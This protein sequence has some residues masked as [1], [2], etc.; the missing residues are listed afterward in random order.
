MIDPEIGD[1]HLEIKEKVDFWHTRM[2]SKLLRFNTMADFWR[3][4]KPTRPA[5]LSGFA[6]PQST[7]TTR[8]TE[9]I[10][11]FLYRALTA[12]QP[13]F[14][15]L[16]YNPMV[17]QEDL[18]TA[19]SVVGWQM[20]A[21]RYNRKL[22]KACR[23]AALFGT[24]MVEEPWV[25]NTPYF[26]AT[27]FVP[28]S[29][30]QTGFDPLCFDIGSSPWKFVLDFVTEDQLR[31]MSHKMPDVWDP[32]VMEDALTLS[33]QTKNIPPEVNARLANAG[34][35]SYLGSSSQTSKMYQLVIY[36]GPLKSSPTGEFC[37]A[38]L[39]DNATLKAHKSVYKRQPFTVA[40]L[41]EF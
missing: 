40:H 38:T 16:S 24:V 4:L 2:Q 36:Y 25:V 31:A 14:Q 37:A 5:D 35:Q 10:A 23:S 9:A 41:N 6:N 22:L 33:S 39:N 19:E 26:E 32:Q 28:R 30:L 21:T 20:T 11:T 12:A 18:W 29:L 1:V 8:A 15:F 17:T 34:Y 27:D 7:E 3:L 13:N